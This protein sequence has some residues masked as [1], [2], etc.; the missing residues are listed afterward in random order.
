MA[1][2]HRKKKPG[3]GFRTVAENKKAR[4][5]YDLEDRFEA[6][7]ALMG[8]EV[9]ALRQH[10]ATLGESYAQVKDDEVWLV[11][12]HIPEFT[13][14]NRN[15]HEVV[16]PRRLLLHKREIRKLGIAV[17]RQGMTL[18]PLRIYFNRRGRAKLELA[19]AKGRKLFDKRAA[20]KKRDWERQKARLLKA[21]G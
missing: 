9:K 14:G 2:Q 7:L 12:C 18:V 5:A 8:T 19:L 20:E 6:G 3:D 10:G 1:R 16:R 21:N 4:R 11:N 13:Q 17:Q 15:N